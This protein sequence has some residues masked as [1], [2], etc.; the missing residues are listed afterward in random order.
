MKN[1]INKILII[2]TG[3]TFNKTYNQKTGKNEVA[4]NSN[5]IKEILQHSYNIKY[6]IKELV[7]KDSLEFN[8][9]DRELIYQTIRTSKYQHIIVIHGTDTM[10]D[11]CKFIDRMQKQKCNTANKTIVFVGA[12][13]P[14]AFDNTQSSFNLGVAIGFLEQKA[15]KPKNNIFIA[16]GGVVKPYKTIKKNKQKAIFEVK[17][18]N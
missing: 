2:N 13:T 1:N 12:M 5:A 16:M 3:G 9:N 17:N 18:S 8:D 11:T 14:F 6:K 4:Q 15:K 7:L 10:S